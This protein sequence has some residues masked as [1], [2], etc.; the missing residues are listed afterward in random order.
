MSAEKTNVKVSKIKQIPSQYYTP[1]KT[2]TT[3]PKTE[4]KSQTD[5]IDT[6]MVSE[7]VK[8]EQT[9]VRQSFV[10][11]QPFWKTGAQKLFRTMAEKGKRF[12][13]ALRATCLALVADR[14]KRLVASGTAC[15][16]LMGGCMTAVLTTCSVAIHIKLGEKEIGDL[17]SEKVYYEILSDVKEEIYN[18]ADIEFEPSG[19][20]SV[21]RV[22]IGK[23]EYTNAEVVKEKLKSTSEEM[24]PAWAVSVDKNT[25]F[26]LSTQ[27]EALSVL[28]RLK[29]QYA[30]ENSTISFASKIEVEKK[31]VPMQILKTEEEAFALLT[32]ENAPEINIRSVSE[33]EGNEEIPFETEQQEDASAYEGTVSVLQEGVVGSRYA[34]YYVEKINGEIVNKKTI[35][36]ELL[37]EP[38]KQIEAIGT[39]ERPSSVGTGEF[40]RPTSGTFTSSF[41]SR[42]GRNHNG[43]DI[44]AGTGTP[45]YASDNG[46]VIYSQYNDGGYGYLIQ[47]DHGNGYVTYYGHC[48]ELLAKVGDVVAKGDLI[49]K[50]GN[51]GRS[52]GPHLHFEVRKNGEVQNPENYLN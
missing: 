45:V 3:V 10:L 29:Q 41:G 51:T 6:P 12:P 8:T 47:I 34:K 42:W 21:N 33:W 4:K 32:G 49:A 9:S 7:W 22:L 19:E 39:K 37:Q 15:I 18:T 1:Q 46:T 40:A 28:E 36:E 30:E 14:A 16:L 2:Q 11:K 38:V 5:N 31:F 43:I 27:P 50:V 35:K 26:A 52:T 20:L 48:S 17:P 13:S 44:G 24:I 25:V 23:G